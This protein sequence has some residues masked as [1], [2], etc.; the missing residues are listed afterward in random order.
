MT[1]LS[2]R[3]KQIESRYPIDFLNAKKYTGGSLLALWAIGV[4]YA[5]V[6]DIILIANVTSIVISLMLLFL[7]LIGVIEIL[8][9]R[10]TNDRDIT[11]VA[12]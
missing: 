5:G 4:S 8:I 2:D 9:G 12:S 10:S 3:F 11:K 6:T 1:S 7:F